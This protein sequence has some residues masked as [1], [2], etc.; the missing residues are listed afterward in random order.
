MSQAS[1]MLFGDFYNSIFAF[2]KVYGSSRV[3]SVQTI[4][5]IITILNN[6]I[7]SDIKV[8]QRS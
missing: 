3:Q 6:S 4:N 2:F 7:L 5:E 1:A 8:T